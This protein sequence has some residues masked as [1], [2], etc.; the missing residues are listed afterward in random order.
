MLWN[1]VCDTLDVSWNFFRDIHVCCTCCDGDVQYAFVP[2]NV[3]DLRIAVSKNCVAGSYLFCVTQ[4]SKC[5][6]VETKHSA[7][8]QHFQTKTYHTSRPNNV[9]A[10]V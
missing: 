9:E 4:S 8:Q 3:Y 1:R 5:K 10:V 2:C 7:A 6:L